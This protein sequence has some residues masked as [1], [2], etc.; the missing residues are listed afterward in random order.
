MMSLETDDERIVGVLHDVC[1]DCPGWSLHRLAEEGFS[2]EVITAIDSVTKRAG[3]AY[4]QFV[5]R[6]SDD[7]VGIRVKLADLT[8]N[9]A[10]SRLPA[11]TE[12]DLLRVEKYNRAIACIQHRLSSEASH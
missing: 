8:D 2:P 11:P 9:I 1:E 10:M 6:A 4:D 5:A 7:P 12:S 3:E